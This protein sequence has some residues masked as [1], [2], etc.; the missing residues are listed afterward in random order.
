[1]FATHG[2]PVGRQGVARA[3]V[4][5]PLSKSDAVWVCAAEP[6]VPAAETMTCAALTAELAD[7]VSVAVAPDVTC[8]GLMVA[9]TPGGAVTES[10]S[11]CAVPCTVAVRTV[12]VIWPPAASVAEGVA[13]DTL[14]S[15][16]LAR[17]TGHPCDASS[18][19]PCTVKVP[20]AVVTLPDE[21][22]HRSPTSLPVA[23]FHAWGKSGF[24]PGVGWASVVASVSSWELT[25]VK[26]RN[27]FPQSGITM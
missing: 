20:R 26:L 8:V 1:M 17:N 4:Q 18:H 27:E 23:L 24:D 25:I 3:G 12:D 16:A 2:Y 6:V 7:T 15:L 19:S 11:V 14:K 21:L 5:P 13:N 10:V 9:V 22:W